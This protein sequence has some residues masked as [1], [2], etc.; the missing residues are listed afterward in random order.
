MKDESSSSE[1]DDEEEE[2]EQ[3]EEASGEE[4]EVTTAFMII[5]H[6]LGRNVTQSFS[7]ESESDGISESALIVALMFVSM[8][9][10]HSYSTSCCHQRFLY[11]D[12]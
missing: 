10:F 1:D 4:E 6:V 2:E 3:E 9:G 12:L 7:V 5:N 11:L 8:C